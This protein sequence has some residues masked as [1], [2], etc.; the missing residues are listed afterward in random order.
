MDRQTARQ[1]MHE[2]IDRV[3]TLQEHK[4]P[5]EE[6]DIQYSGITDGLTVVKY[7]KYTLDAKE[8]L[9]LRTEF[10]KTAYFDWDNGYI[11][12]IEKWAEQEEKD[13]DIIRD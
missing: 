8:E 1:K 2:F 10:Y 7:T 5:D 4:K 13:H 11:D 9:R 3:M 6:Y 12:E